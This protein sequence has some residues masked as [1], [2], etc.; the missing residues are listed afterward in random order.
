VKK[1]IIGLILA[2]L[3]IIGLILVMLL[4]PVS[5][6]KSPAPESE[7]LIGLEIVDVTIT[8]YHSTHDTEGNYDPDRVEATLSWETTKPSYYCFEV[9]PVDFDYPSNSGGFE[10]FDI[11][12]PLPEQ[13]KHSSSIVLKS[14]KLHR[15]IITVWDQGKNYFTQSEIFW[16]PVVPKT[17]PPPAPAS[18]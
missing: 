8:S 6:A 3:L 18:Q 9:K 4:V 12:T 7:P 1:L 13:V 10:K 16:A 5:C 15:Y 14:G 11:S 2:M 17:T